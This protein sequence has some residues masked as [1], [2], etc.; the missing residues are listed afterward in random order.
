VLIHWTSFF[1]AKFMGHLKPTIIAF[2]FPK[3]K[4]KVFG[5]PIAK[6]SRILPY[7]IE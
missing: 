2:F 7:E 6:K 1:K 5:Y 3:I 4:N